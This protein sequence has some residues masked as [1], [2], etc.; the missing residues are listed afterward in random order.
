MFPA[1]RGGGALYILVGDHPR[2]RMSGEREQA[3]VSELEGSLRL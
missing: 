1:D 2:A 3:F